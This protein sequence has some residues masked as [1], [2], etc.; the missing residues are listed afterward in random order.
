MVSSALPE[1]SL[2]LASPESSSD[3]Y[4]LYASSSLSSLDYACE[5]A[6][7]E[8][9]RDMD[10]SE[11]SELIEPYCCDV[12]VSGDID[13]VSAR[14][15]DDALE[16]VH[17]EAT[18]AERLGGTME[19]LLAVAGMHASKDI[20]NSSFSFRSGSDW[21]RAGTSDAARA[22]ECFSSCAPW[23]KDCPCS[24]IGSFSRSHCVTEKVVTRTGSD[25]PSRWHT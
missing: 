14:G 21:Y 16:G 24:W 9:G 3:T 23:R 22:S 5:I 15:A 19:R 2:L 18:S 17:A 12:G 25:C 4:S 1:S 6:V 20:T 10:E 13:S 11:A 8:L 7:G